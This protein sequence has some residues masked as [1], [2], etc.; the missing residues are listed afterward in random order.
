MA[1]AGVVAP[2]P[3]GQFSKEQWQQWLAQEQWRGGKHPEKT[4]EIIH[5]IVQG[6][7]F[8]EQ[9]VR[10]AGFSKFVRPPL[11]IVKEPPKDGSLVPKFAS[12][13]PRPNAVALTPEK[14]HEYADY[15]FDEIVHSGGRG[16]VSM[17]ATVPNQSF[18]AG[19]EEC[20]HAVHRQQQGILP[21]PSNIRSLSGAE[22]DALDHEFE[23]LGFQVLVAKEFGFPE[24]TKQVLIRRWQIANALRQQQ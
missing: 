8:V 19:V 17:S 9:K 11:V 18:L 6:I 12:Y 15:D 10:A 13:W 16:E 14:L 22:Y 2:D 7:D 23:A 20:H 5:Q 1:E 21:I 3:N 4:A 24:V